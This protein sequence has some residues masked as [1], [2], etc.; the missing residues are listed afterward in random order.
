MKFNIEVDMT[1]EEFKELTGFKNYS[2]IMS[3]TY[4]QA[5]IDNPWLKITQELTQQAFK[6]M[7]QK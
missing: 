5:V 1:P 3:E 4:N 7:V 2:D 6:N